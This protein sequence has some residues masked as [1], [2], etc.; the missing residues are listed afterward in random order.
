MFFTHFA[1]KNQLPGSSRIGTL[2]GIG[3]ICPILLIFILLSIKAG[4]VNDWIK[5]FGK[6]FGILS[7]EQMEE[8]MWEV[9]LTY[10]N[11]SNYVVSFVISERVAL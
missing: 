4:K 11:P 5:N 2:G 9:F 6:I 10:K 8:V 1:S 7:W 3:L